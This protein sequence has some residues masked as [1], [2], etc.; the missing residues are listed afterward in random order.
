MAKKPTVT[1]VTME[2]NETPEVVV[3]EQVEIVEERKPSEQ[4]LLEMEAGRQALAAFAAS[5]RKETE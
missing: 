2:S 1:E 5:A 3:T 4:T